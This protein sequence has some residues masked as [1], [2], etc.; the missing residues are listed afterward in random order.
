MLVS[1]EVPAE[2]SQHLDH[3]SP[4]TFTGVADKASFEHRTAK[5][6]YE[7]TKERRCF[8]SAVGVHLSVRQSVCKTGKFEAR[9]QWQ[10]TLQIDSKLFCVDADALQNVLDSHFTA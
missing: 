6:H 10:V 5:E 7:A 9:N 8:D 1:N 4:R 3:V 2:S